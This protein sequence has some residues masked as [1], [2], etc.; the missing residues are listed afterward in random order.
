MIS[1][2]GGERGSPQRAQRAERMDEREALV[3]FEAP[4]KSF[5][6]VTHNESPELYAAY[7][8]TGIPG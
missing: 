8:S 4:S 3:P 5:A 1:D 7:H 2:W 6:I